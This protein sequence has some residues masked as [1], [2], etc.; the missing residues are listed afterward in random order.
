V[1]GQGSPWGRF[2]AWTSGPRLRRHAAELHATPVGTANIPW[3]PRGMGLRPVP[4]DVPCNDHPKKPGHEKHD[5]PQKKKRKRRSKEGRGNHVAG[6]GRDAA[7]S[8]SGR[9][10]EQPFLTGL[11]GFTGLDSSILPMFHHSSLHFPPRFR[12]AASPGESSSA[13][14][15]LCGKIGCSSSI[16]DPFNAKGARAAKETQTPDRRKRVVSSQ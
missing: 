10:A 15:R 11:T 1:D 7:P 6:L 16:P 8:A 4:L 9:T 13:P 3:L 14:L 5:K 12:P 2:V